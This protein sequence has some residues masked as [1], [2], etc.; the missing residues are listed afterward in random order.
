MSVVKPPR[1]QYFITAG[2]ADYYTD[3]NQIFL[4]VSMIFFISIFFFFNLGSTQGSH[5]AFGGQ[6]SL[7]QPRVFPHIQNHLSHLS[8]F[9]LSCH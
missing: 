5:V 4:I 2:L 7:A 3:C 8:L 1:P 6:C 9:C